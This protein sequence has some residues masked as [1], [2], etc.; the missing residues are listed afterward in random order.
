MQRVWVLMRER[1]GEHRNFDGQQLCGG[2]VGGE[3]EVLRVGD[4]DAVAGLQLVSIYFYAA[5]QQEDVDAVAGKG[6]R[7]GQLFAG[8]K[9]AEGETG[10]LVDP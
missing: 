9:M 6:G 7:V 3:G 1:S 2:F 10:V 4:A 8:R 5:F